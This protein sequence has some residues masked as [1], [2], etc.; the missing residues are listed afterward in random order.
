MLN[1]YEMKGRWGE[2]TKLLDETNQINDI[3]T[4]FILKRKL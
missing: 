3:K 1:F 4:S 2:M